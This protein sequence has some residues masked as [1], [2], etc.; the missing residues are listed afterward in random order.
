VDLTPRPVLDAPAAPERRRKW[1]PMAVL[2]L[3]VVAGGV[4][5]SRFL[6]SAVDYYC[7]VDEIGVKSGCE[8][9]RSVRV[10]GTVDAGSVETDGGEVTFTMSFNGARLPVHLDEEPGGI[11]DECM[12]VVVHGR[13][14]AD[15]V[16]D[17]SKVEVKHSNEYTDENED[18]LADA[19]AKAT[20]CSPQA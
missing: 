18:R 4:I 14:G 8:A 11:F 3:L 6:T 15:G 2:G 20:E 9:E 13:I 1:L 10:Q 7:N 5:V 19:E 17:G 16:L 12:P